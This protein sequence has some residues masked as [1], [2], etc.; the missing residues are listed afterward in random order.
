MQSSQGH[1]DRDQLLSSVIP[2]AAVGSHAYIH[3]N[4]KDG[5]EKSFLLRQENGS[6]RERGKA[7][8]A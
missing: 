2:T 5:G 8:I 4:L 3:F 1:H 6:P 7:L